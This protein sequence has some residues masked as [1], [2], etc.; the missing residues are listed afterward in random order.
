M[1]PLA[2]AFMT[3]ASP[4]VV[5]QFLAN[6][7]YPSHEAYLFALADAL[8]H[9][10]EAIHRAGFVLQLDCPELA[11]GWNTH[12]FKDATIDD[13]R[14]HI[15]LH[16]AALNHAIASIPAD[17]IRLHLCWGNI[18]APHV[19]DIPL[20][21]IL[22][23]V[24]KANVGAISFEGANPRHA[25]EW[26]VFEEVTLPEDKVIIPGV[27]D[28]T[29]NVV[30]HPELVAER[31]VRYASLVGRERVIAGSDCGF[32]SFARAATRV[33]PTVTWAKL[34]AMAEGARIASAQLWR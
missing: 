28:S 16:V 24:L 6:E 3:A 4:G 1:G 34:Q 27:L 31:I 2:D 18:E 9:E 25:H 29:T 15:A 11:L 22:D 13:F 26:R 5:W 33:H 19:R 14:K 7:Y 23:I 30:E 20:V 17:R 10:Y 12:P 32:S 21:Q 8:R